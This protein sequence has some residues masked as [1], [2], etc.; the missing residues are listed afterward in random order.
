MTFTALLIAAST[1]PERM[2]AVL[3]K[4]WE[5]V[6]VSG[7]PTEPPATGWQPAVVPSSVFVPV[8][9]VRTSL[10][11]RISLP[12]KPHSGRTY[13]TF[14]S[15]GK[16]AV[17]WVD[18]RKVDQWKNSWTPRTI[19]IT[20]FVKGKSKAEALIRCSD[21]ASLYAD[22]F[23]PPPGAPEEAIRGKVL[24]PLG[25]YLDA[26]GLSLPVRLSTRPSAHVVESGV[27]IHTSVRQ[28]T[29]DVKGRSVG[30]RAGWK[31]ALEAVS[32]GGR[33]LARETRKLGM[34]GLNDKGEFSLTASFPKARLWSPETPHLYQLRMSL[35][36]ERGSL[37]DASQVRFGF[38]EVWTEGQ[39]FLLNGV[40]R[41]L[42]AT[43]TWPET[44]VIPRAEVRRRLLEVKRS[45]AIAFRLHIGPW[46]KEFRDVA[47]E[48]GL[49]I[50][51]ES[52]LYTDGPGMY[53]YR[54]PRFWEN[55]KEVLGGL[56]EWSGQHPSVVLWSLGNEILFMGNQ[57]HDP[58]LPKKQGDLARW[59]KAQDPTR[60]VTFEADLDPD[61]AYDVIGLH[62]PH[63]L[64]NQHAYPIITDWLAAEK[65]TEAGGGMLGTSSSSFKWDRRKPLYIGE[66]LWV[67]MGDY[68][69][70]S[71]FFGPE[72]YADR[73]RYNSKAR[74]LSWHHQTVAYRRAG[75]TGLTPWTAFGFG[76]IDESQESIEAQRRFYKPVA[77]FVKN[78]ALRA[79][80]WASLQL[81]LDVFNDSAEPLDLGLR[82]EL[83]GV[84][85]QTESFRLNP[86]ATRRESFTLKAPTVT[87]ARKVK[88]RVTLTSKGRV[89]DSQDL[90]MEVEP[91]QSLA[92]P[93]GSTLV[94]VTGREELEK[95][96]IS[97]P[98][99]T[100]ILLSP[101]ILDPQPSPEAGS[102][103][104]VGA[105]YPD[106][107]ALKEA[108]K[109][110][111]SVVI[112]EQNSLAALELPLELTDHL[113]TMAFAL[114]PGWP[115]LQHWGQDMVVARR[116]LV[117]S[118]A[119][120]LRVLAVSGGPRSLAQGPVGILRFGK[121]S[122]VFLQTL[123]GAKKNE[124]PAADQAV[125]AGLSLA[126]SEG[127]AREGSVALVGVEATFA[128]KLQ[129]LGLKTVAAGES[130]MNSPLSGVILGEELPAPWLEKR[131]K[132]EGLPVLW[133]AHAL[134]S[135]PDRIQKAKTMGILPKGLN[136]AAQP[137]T[138][139]WA[140]A[141]KTSDPLLRG[142]SAEE[143]TLTTL[144]AGW[145]RVTSPRSGVCASV[146]APEENGKT[147]VVLS[148]SQFRG[149]GA[150][151]EGDSL[152]T[153]RRSEVV[154]EVR[155]SKS[156]W[157]WLTISAMGSR[158]PL[159]R[160]SVNGVRADWQEL[161]NGAS[162][163][164]VYLPKGQSQISLAM[165]N[166][167]SWGENGPMLRL[168]KVTLTDTS[169]LPSGVRLQ[170]STGAAASW[171][172]GKSQ[173][174][175]ITLTPQAAAENSVKADRILSALCANLGME[176]AV[177]DSPSTTSLP[178]NRFRVE[179]GPYNSS[180]PGILEMR[181][182]GS[183]VTEV[184]AAQGGQFIAEFSAESS[185]AKGEYA[186]F[187]L[188]VDGVE[189]GRAKCTG[190]SL[191]KLRIG[192]FAMEK[193]R[194]Q[195]RIRF[196]NDAGG[197]G[198]DRNLFL[199]GMSVGVIRP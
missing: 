90:V 87:L 3:E 147:G 117:R 197:D 163:S 2:E 155:R 140:G 74:R 97:D 68:S 145:D 11:H 93:A 96:S 172:W 165:D 39:H 55:M 113:S 189:V 102:L 18:G 176:F 187:A 92:G 85:P 174:S 103:P 142:L 169:D 171:M 156:C 152:V 199:R 107:R 108:V 104:V 168:Q 38:R 170:S 25:G 22:G 95:L 190:P 26:I 173:V 78:Q 125:R 137:S 50:V 128:K 161:V 130:A 109:K 148:A 4:G 188:E 127:K 83:S 119:Q 34:V 14:E 62:Y 81:D 1:A 194:R 160:I 192:P 179:S 98:S 33:G 116:Q 126:S 82:V 48:I 184:W 15:A 177:P 132:E 37:K 118:G 40:R 24:W 17:L 139:A 49:M 181:S 167:A 94:R 131:I 7:I 122:F 111:A 136:A 138:F 141:W 59:F 51:E 35:Y 43:S 180:G 100:S 61:G 42:L 135:A 71:V 69:P 9:G 20:D 8:P 143:F 56:L 105:G 46:Q 63:E 73:D 166:G 79:F 80:G 129:A 123:A 70:G 12:L 76:A 30:A 193:G 114:E 153:Y 151:A 58:D 162:K 47:D 134:G 198:E 27:R 115:S 67:P 57:A 150:A 60:L 101:G 183:A 23:V 158:R 182:D 186:E 64:P 149:T 178:L 75:V 28:G 157:A 52:P 159:I 154:A 16:D 86:A 196:T 146:F 175:A 99:R 133:L 88:G 36:D 44:G 10:W 195:L 120:G 72:A 32:T 41:N 191:A 112:L 84:E 185:P 19:D 77:V 91:R 13:L 89:V 110:G 121:G 65:T 53:A 29:L 45:N 66:Y 124:D 164:L 144:P 31:V 54:D 21:R 106:T 6:Q 5:S